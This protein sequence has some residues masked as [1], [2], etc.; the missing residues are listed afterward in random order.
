MKRKKLRLGKEK[1]AE[2]VDN[3][4]GV[5][6]LYEIIVILPFER[7]RT[8]MLSMAKQLESH[9][10]YSVASMNYDNQERRKVC[11]EVQDRG[12]K[13]KTKTF[14]L[15]SMYYVIVTF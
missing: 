11:N 2:R 15:R 5:L 10:L 14:G 1:L 12:N 7:N 13:T 9:S 4:W 3:H 6:T 8:L